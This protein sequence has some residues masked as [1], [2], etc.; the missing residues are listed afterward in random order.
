MKR[1]VSKTEFQYPGVLGFPRTCLHSVLSILDCVVTRKT[2]LPSVLLTE[3]SYHLI[4]LLAADSK[5]GGPILRF[6]RANKL[7]FPLHL[8]YCRATMTNGKFVQAFPTITCILE[9][10]LDARHLKQM[11]WLMKTLACELWTASNTKLITYLRYL[12]SFLGNV[13]NN[14]KHQESMFLHQILNI[15]LSDLKG[16]LFC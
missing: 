11:S 8:K 16:K 3:P 2:N 14:E 6:I 10:F 15:E 9:D 1:D 7:F 5:T 13:S 4:Y 12:I